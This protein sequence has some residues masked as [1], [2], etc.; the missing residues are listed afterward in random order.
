MSL[1]LVLGG[2]LLLSMLLRQFGIVLLALPIAF[3]FFV[4][5]VFGGQR[6]VFSAKYDA[7]TRKIFPAKKDEV[8]TQ[9]QVAALFRIG[10]GRV[11]AEKLAFAADVSVKAAK[12]FLDRQ[13][14]DGA[15]DVEAGDSE[16]IY[17]K[18]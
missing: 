8:I 5:Q 11:T 16:L 13:V 17:I 18:K 15:L 14:V 4:K 3:F 9:E 1:P 12:K 6:D 7:P 2:L 10:G